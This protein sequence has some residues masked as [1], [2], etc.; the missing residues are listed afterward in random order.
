MRG[1]FDSVVLRQVVFRHTSPGRH[2]LS[3]R[4]AQQ[5]GGRWNLRRGS[6][7]VYLADSLQTCIAEFRRT[8]AGQARGSASLLP[9]DLHHIAVDGVRVVDLAAPGALE[10]ARL[11]LGDIAAA[12]WTKCQ[13]VGEEVALA[14]Y[15]GLRAPSATGIANVIVLFEDRFRESEVRL[16]RTEDLGQYL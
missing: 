15:A 16:I 12:D 8:A 7:A 11:G 3:G 9:R 6:A 13:Q 10:A 14:G 1:D 5:F 4:G 2:P